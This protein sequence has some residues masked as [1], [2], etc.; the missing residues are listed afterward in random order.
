MLKF[1]EYLYNNYQIKTHGKKELDIVSRSNPQIFK[2]GQK[3]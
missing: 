2:G 1:H 3:D